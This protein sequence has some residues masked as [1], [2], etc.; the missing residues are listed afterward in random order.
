MIPYRVISC[1]DGEAAVE[2][3]CAA[4][5][6]KRAP[7]T[8]DQDG[9]ETIFVSPAKRTDCQAETYAVICDAEGCGT[10]L[11]PEMCWRCYAQALDVGADGC[12]CS[13]LEAMAETGRAVLVN[14]ERQQ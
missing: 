8:L 5:A 11:Y 10:E 4:C 13:E 2:F 7:R 3:L 9:W 14:G 1:R 12:I 6:A